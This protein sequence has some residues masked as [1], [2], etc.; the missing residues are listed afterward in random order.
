MRHA[1]AARNHPSFAVQIDTI[2]H[3]EKHLRGEQEHPESEGCGVQMQ[4]QRRMLPQETLG[5]Q[6][7]AEQHSYPKNGEPDC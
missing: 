5:I 1:H 3:D 4:E 7:E 6:A 2:T